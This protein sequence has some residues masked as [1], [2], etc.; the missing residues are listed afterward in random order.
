MSS[1][2]KQLVASEISAC[3]NVYR[4]FGYWVDVE[5]NLPL[6]ASEV[7][8]KVDGAGLCLRHHGV[9]EVGVGIECD[10]RHPR[11]SCAKP[12]WL[13]TPGPALAVNAASPI[14]MI[15]SSFFIP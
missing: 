8:F 15:D 10:C 5:N 12:R 14:A 7:A 4:D 1:D 2:F 6:H 3:G 9:C 13:N 11:H